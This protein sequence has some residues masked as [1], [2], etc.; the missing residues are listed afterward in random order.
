MKRF[1]SVLFLTL[2][3]VA[4]SLAQT[5]TGRLQGTVSSAD[6]ALPGVTVNATDN[7]TGREQSVVTNESGIYVFPQLEFGTYT[8]RISATGFKA[9][10]AEEVKIDVGRTN[11]LDP[12][13]EVGNVQETVTVTAGADVVTAT[14]AQ[15]SNTISPQQILSLPLVARN[16]LDLTRLQPGVASNSAQA[17]TI[18]GLRT[19]FTNI[20][21]DGINIQDTFIRTNATDFAPGRPS[22]DDTAEFTLTS[23]NAEADQGYGG[24][25]IRLVTPRGTKD[26]HGALFAY[27]RNSE[28][29]AN[30][31]FRNRSNTPRPFR[32][33]NQFGG[34]LSGPLPL[35]GF[36]EG[37]PTVVKDKGFFFFAYEGIRD[38]LGTNVNRTILTPSARTGVFQFNRTNTTAFTNPFVSCA[39]AA[40]GAL[41][42][43]SDIIGFARSVGLAV[44]AG[45]NPVVLANILSQTPTQGN[46]AGGDGLNTTGFTLNR[47]QTQNRDQ[48]SSRFDV[49]FNDRYSLLGIYNYN[50]ENNLRPDAD[51]TLFTATPAVIQSSINKQFTTAF[52]SIIS[53][54]FVNE[55]RGGIFTSQVPFNRTDAVPNYFTTSGLITVPENTF[56]FQ[57]RNT[58][59]LN[60][61]DNADFVVGNHTLR[62]GG[63]LQYFKVDASNDVSTV[64]T[65]TL[66]GAG[67]ALFTNTVGGATSFN[68]V[69]GI[70]NVQLGTANALLSLLTG[71]FSSVTQS[72]NVADINSGFV[73][74]ATAFTPFRYENHSLYV[75]DRWS[76]NSDLTLTLGVRYELFPALRLINGVALEPVISD[77]ENIAAAVLN[78]NGTL[79]PIGGNAGR[80][81]AYYKTDKN[82]FAPNF[83]IA[84]APKFE[85]GIGKYLLGENKTVLRAGYS[86][87]YGN[88]SI[89]T[90]IN[91]SAIGNAGLG[92]TAITA[93]NLNGQFL[94][95]ST[96]PTIPT[97]AAPVFPRTYL[98]NNAAGIGNFFGTVFAIDPNLETP[99][100]EQYSVG[101]QRE[102]F[103]NMALEV[104]YVGSRSKNLARGI[105]INQIDIFSNGFL[106]DFLRAQN[107]L[108]VGGDPFCTTAGCQPL[109]IFQQSASSPGRLGVAPT[110]AATPAGT[111]VRNNF[112]NALNNGTPA[113]LA[114]LFINNATN[115]NNQ[116]SSA[117]PNATPF[118]NFL[119]NPAAG[120]VDVFLNGASYNYNSLQIELRRRFSDGLYFQANYTFSKNLTNAIG[121]SQALFEPLL[122]NNNPGLEWQRA[123]FDQ[124]HVLNFNGIYQLPFGKGRRFLNQG[125]FID[126][127]FGGFEFSGLFQVTS[128][129]PITLVDTRGTLNRAGRS[130]RQTPFSTLTNEQIRA[131]AGTYVGSSV[132]GDNNVY[133]INPAVLSITPNA[134]GTYSS[135][136]S[137][138]YSLT[139]AGTFPGQAFF[140]VQPGQTGNVTRALFDGP[141]YYNANVALLK[142]IRFTESMRLQLRAEAFNVFN[143]TNFAINAAQQLSNI[144][145]TTFGQYTTT[146]A[147]RELQ[148]AARFEF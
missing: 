102:F 122:D 98:Q 18:N 109:T 136:G 90:S 10:V 73:R 22:V 114:L 120:A 121:T 61:Q 48:Y 129:A 31:F 97:P 139:G 46:A 8:V 143:T 130:T 75:S 30:S 127:V 72:F 37:G 28:F 45:I 103:G 54:N 86:H 82:N 65:V 4:A 107:N 34:K 17:T 116:P 118:V 108:R 23:S 74:G 1:S 44:P 94:G 83:G 47:L 33:R 81:D 146:F 111:L 43:V 88:D 13:L 71:N 76:V 42:T 12:I 113:D 144:N 66:G 53:S 36:G 140:N 9:F 96:I 57:G 20:T 19:T 21:R 145:S 131:L 16:P 39:S 29:G 104:R 148:F 133:F 126:R 89:V 123:D 78:R 55:V 142:N 138:G 51:T 105:D 112:L 69:G 26:F 80:E 132:A 141:N 92:R 134:N 84:Y 50:N 24:A 59:G 2:I 79:Q 6:G 27:N 62:F 49:D 56:L 38:P 135:V 87:V 41:C 125:G 77:P 137:N 11:S 5:T 95:T 85:S 67:A 128:G 58:E 52:R 100:V 99:M 91:N 147:P 101:V 119:A 115:V 32:N 35:L 7:T 64:P 15:V 93:A 117:N 40:V 106:N 63:Q 60:I 3:F 70:S 14:T 124:T 25:Q 110:T 68:N